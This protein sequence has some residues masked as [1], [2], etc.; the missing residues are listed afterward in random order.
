[1]I[2]FAFVLGL[3]YGKTLSIKLLQI[4]VKQFVIVLFLQIDRLRC[5]LQKISAA[6]SS[7]EAELI[8]ARKELDRMRLEL[9]VLRVA[10]SCADIRFL[11]KKKRFH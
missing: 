3:S 9:E 5:R 2:S 6:K 11:I 10:V 8:Q 1:M 7:N 4:P